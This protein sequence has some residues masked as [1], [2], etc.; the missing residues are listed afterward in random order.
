[1]QKTMTDEQR[2]AK[3]R[4]GTAG[5]KARLTNLCRNLDTCIGLLQAPRTDPTSVGPPQL[6][7]CGSGGSAATCQQSII[8]TK[9]IL[10]KSSN[11]T[12]MDNGL[13]HLIH[14]TQINKDDLQKIVIQKRSNHVNEVEQ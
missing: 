14:D 13:G 11:C 9:S 3:V 8:L 10:K 6:Q 1:M 7:A 4:M 12:D 5:R 2:P